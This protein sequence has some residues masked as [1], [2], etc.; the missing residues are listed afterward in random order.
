MDDPGWAAAL[1]SFLGS[2]GGAIKVATWLIERANAKKMK[3][4]SAIPSDLPV[5]NVA[6]PKDPTVEE[7]QA[8]IRALRQAQQRELWRL[9]AEKMRL[10]HELDLTGEDQARIAQASLRVQEENERLRARVTELEER[11]RAIDAGHTRLGPPA[12]RTPGSQ[13]RLPPVSWPPVVQEID[14]IPTPPKGGRIPR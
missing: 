12:P 6:E 9:D 13:P 1:I 5:A 3:R 4:I 8:E 10:Q 2:I 7:L 11:Q 14:D